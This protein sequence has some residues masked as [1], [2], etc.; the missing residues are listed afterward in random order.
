MAGP[1]GGD[2]HGFLQVVGDFGPLVVVEG[3]VVHVVEELFVHAVAA[4][5]PEFL[6]VAAFDED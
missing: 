5:D 3:E 2:G 4:K 1:G 6:L